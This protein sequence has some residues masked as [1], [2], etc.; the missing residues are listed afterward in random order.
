MSETTPGGGGV[1]QELGL[2]SEQFV[3][4]HYHLLDQQ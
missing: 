1:R 3:E 4:L 2:R